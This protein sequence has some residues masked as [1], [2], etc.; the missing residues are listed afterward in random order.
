MGNSMPP[1]ETPV[2]VGIAQYTQGRET[3]DPLDPLGLMILAGKQA[4]ADTGNEKP[5]HYC[6]TLRVVNIISHT[7]RDVCGDL[8][9]AL[10]ITPARNFYSTMGGN[11]PQY[12]LNQAANDIA[13]G[14]SRVTLITGAEAACALHRSRKKEITLDWPAKIPPEKEGCTS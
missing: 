1:V 3:P 11:T 5:A 14:R 10:G 4:L 8:A 12:Y 9:N 7:Y 6:D 13:L 2:I